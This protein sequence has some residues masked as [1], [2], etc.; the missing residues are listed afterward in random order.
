[1]ILGVL[2]NE[3]NA[4]KDIGDIINA[5]LLYFELLCSSVEI[6]FTIRTGTKKS[7]KLLCQ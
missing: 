7:N 2:F 6:Q 5:S 4:F 1:M 3:S